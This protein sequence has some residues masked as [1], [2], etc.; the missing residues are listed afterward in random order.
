MKIFITLRDLDQLDP[1]EPAYAVVKKHLHRMADLYPEDGYLVL[2]DDQRDLVGLLNLPEVKR[3]WLEII[4]L[5]EGCVKRDGHFCLTYLTNNEFGIDLILPD[6]DWLGDPL[7]KALEGTAEE[8]V[9]YMNITTKE[10]D[11]D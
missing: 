6:A 5:S 8:S 11:H 10:N 4:N 1:R 2:V 9:T 7:R 3:P